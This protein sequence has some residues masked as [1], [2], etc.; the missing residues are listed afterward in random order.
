MKYSQRTEF[1]YDP[2]VF[3]LHDTQI[4]LKIHDEYVRRHS[5]RPLPTFFEID[6]AVEH[7]DPLF[8]VPLSSRS[9]ISRKLEIPAINMFQKPTWILTQ[10]GLTPQRKDRFWFSNLG[11][12]E[13]D[14]FPSRGDMVYWNGY[15]SM[16]ITVSVP[17]EAYWQ[18]TG[19]WL[20]LTADCE[21]VPEGDA[22]PLVDLSKISPSEMSPSAGIT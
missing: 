2:E 8:H 4:A 19:I 15:R 3:S 20:G 22:K 5:A 9:P 6:R 17:P 10:L 14:Y 12:I 18:Q 7:L 1:S 21:V 11:L 16:I 13:A